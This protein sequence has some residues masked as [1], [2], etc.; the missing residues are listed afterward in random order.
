MC[1]ISGAF[2]NSMNS[3]LQDSFKDASL[4]YL[5]VRGPDNFGCYYFDNGVLCHTRLSIIDLDPRSNQPFR[6]G[7][8]TLVF[9]GEIYNYM[10][11][12][13]ILVKDYQLKFAT[14]SDTEV[15]AAAIDVLGVE[16]TLARIEGMFA[17]AALNH[18]H[19]TIH[20]CRDSFGMKPLFYYYSKPK[21]M[22]AF[23]SWP[24]VILDSGI[25]N[26]WRIDVD[27]L[28]DC[29][30]AGTSFRDRYLVQDIKQ[31]MPSELI[32]FDLN[33][34][35]IFIDKSPAR[36][37]KFSDPKKKV[38]FKELFHNVVREHLISD[39]PTS[40]FLS[41]G[42]D[43]SCIAASVPKCRAFHLNSD[44]RIFAEQVASTFGHDLEVVEPSIPQAGFLF[45]EIAERTGLVCSNAVMPYAVSKAIKDSG[46][47]VALSANGADELFYGY[48]RTY[49][50]LVDQINPKLKGLA[51]ERGGVRSLAEQIAIIFRDPFVVSNGLGPRFGRSPDNLANDFWSYINRIMG[52]IPEPGN[53][54]RLLELF[55]Y[56]HGDINLTA[57]ATSMLCSIEVRTPFLDR[58]VA[59]FALGLDTDEVINSE[60]GRKAV[61]KRYLRASGVEDS[62][63]A[64]P[65]MGFSLTS[66]Y[67]TGFVAD[68]LMAYQDL[69]GRNFLGGF[70]F[71]GETA[72]RDMNYILPSIFALQKWLEVWVDSG[73]VR[74]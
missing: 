67:R 3:D 51:F 40:I 17:F 43:S 27:G 47:K 48:W 5:H 11:L 39:V 10:E 22:L 59:S 23:A 8:T 68:S 19:R 20:L 25:S 9:N 41:G 53:L 65:K 73:K 38:D 24:A 42:V 37:S 45:R 54:G 62:V 57:D 61:L 15:L 4:K 72:Y 50:P 44:E 30:I 63:W 18:R 26:D 35:E 66:E 16:A 21:G 49:S 69:Q 56:V 55:T 58:R 33:T 31:L 29:L 2:G 28:F 64:R 12:K 6:F 70:P 34:S 13:K 74:V 7:D 46:Y 60:F 36:L 1:G 14:E 52:D 71:D 32:K